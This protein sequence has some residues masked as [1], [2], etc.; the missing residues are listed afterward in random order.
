MSMAQ[1]SCRAHCKEL[2][3]LGLKRV[4]SYKML[5]IIIIRAIFCF[6]KQIQNNSRAERERGHALCIKCR[7]SKRNLS[8]DYVQFHLTEASWK[9]KLLLFSVLFHIDH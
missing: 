9:I 5:I 2:A 1:L 6:N 7:L 4:K 8:L 3:Q